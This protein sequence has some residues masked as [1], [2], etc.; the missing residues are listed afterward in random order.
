MVLPISDIQNSVS[1][2][3]KF[4]PL[5]TAGSFFWASNSRNLI[6]NYQEN[7]QGS[8]S[9]T[10]VAYSTLIKTLFCK[11]GFIQPLYSNLRM[12]KQVLIYQYLS[13]ACINQTELMHTFLLK[14][15]MAQSKTLLS[16]QRIIPINIKH[17]WV[18]N[19]SL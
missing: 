11:Q 7:P 9:L 13:L 3:Q 2:V 18:R 1:V 4:S 6:C 10:K 15:H 5:R 12:N 14:N 8:S 16:R 19:Q 17:K